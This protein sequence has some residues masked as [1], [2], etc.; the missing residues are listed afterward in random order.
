MLHL[1]KNVQLLEASCYG[2]QKVLKEYKYDDYKR[3]A[4][5]TLRV[6]NALSPVV[7]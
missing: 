6:G 2:I 5:Q 4:D 1:D 3:F 7:H